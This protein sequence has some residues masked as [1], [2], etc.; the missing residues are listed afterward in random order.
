MLLLLLLLGDAR[1]ASYWSAELEFNSHHSTAEEAR[2][3][4]LVPL[5]HALTVVIKNET[6]TLGFSMIV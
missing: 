1:L 4:D 6:C 3:I 2:V 5:R